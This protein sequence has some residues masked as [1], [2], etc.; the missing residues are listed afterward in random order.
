M[1]NPARLAQNA[2]AVKDVAS[3]IGSADCILELKLDGIRLMA[4][5]TDTGTRTFTRSGKEQTGKLPAIEAELFANL[6][7]GTWVDGEIVSLRIREDGSVEHHWG[8]A[9]SVMG[10]NVD[11]AARGSGVLT[12]SVFDVMSIGGTDARSLPLSSRRALLEQAF[13]DGTYSAVV[14]TPQM[15][16]TDANVANIIALG[17][18]GAMVKRL[19][20]PYASGQRGR[21]WHKIKA[22]DTVDAVV[23]GYQPGEGR[24]D[25]QLGALLLG[26]YDASGTLIQVAKA[27]GMTDAVRLEMSTNPGAH[28]GTVVE[29]AHMGKMPS[30]GYRHPQFKRAR[31]DKPAAEC[32]IA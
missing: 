24:F 21:G 27:S 13:R 18:E 22:T 20:S 19:S 30:G 4:H 12:Y 5:V 3:V 17:F 14:L 7:A 8:D 23:M 1:F 31:P 25:G 16:A 6:P 15:E 10:S 9:Q 11:R 26:Q 29:F 2:E 28:I 32:V